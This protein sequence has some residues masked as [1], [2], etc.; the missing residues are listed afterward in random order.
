MFL[1]E[2]TGEA[3]EEKMRI[4]STG[5]VGIGLEPTVNM[6][7]LSIEAGLLTLKERATPTADSG[8]AK[9][10]S[11]T[12]NFGYIQDGSGVEKKIMTSTYACLYV[13]S[14]SATTIS[15]SSTPV[16]VAGTTTEVTS[17]SDITV[18]SAGRLTYTGATTR[19]FKADAGISFESAGNNNDYVFYLAKNGTVIGSSAQQNFIGTGSERKVIPLTCMPELA[20]NDYL[21]VYVENITD[22]D[23]CTIDY[24][25]F[26]ILAIG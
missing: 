2:A 12:D 20:Q 6:D 13:S 4:S 11:K 15:S 26:N 16:L 24:M 22:T 23:N 8:Y 1:T 9:L 7:G 5:N 25:N 21:E 18:S 19:R 14:S 17:T 10:Y 3:I